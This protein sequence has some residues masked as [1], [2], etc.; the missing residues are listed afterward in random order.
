[1]C[2]VW[3]AVSVSDIMGG[4]KNRLFPRMAT[5]MNEYR[6]ETVIK[7]DRTLTLDNLPF[8]AGDA[9]E[10]IILERSVAPQGEN[11]YPLRGQPLRYDHPSEPVAE[12]DW[13][14]LR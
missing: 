1:M 10:V 12:E 9:V 13:Q 6:L 2:G 7:K 14:A 8:Q 5:W 11:R 4:R 3:P